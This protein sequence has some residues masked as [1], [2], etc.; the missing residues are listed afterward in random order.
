MKPFRVTFNKHTDICSHDISYYFSDT[1]LKIDEDGFRHIQDQLCEGYVEGDLN[2]T[3]PDTDE[4]YHG[5]WHIER[6]K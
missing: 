3:D 2:I 6:S 1:D 5:F 4:T